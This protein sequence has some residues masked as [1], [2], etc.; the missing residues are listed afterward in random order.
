MS[1]LQEALTRVSTAATRIQR[2]CLDKYRYSSQSHAAGRAGN[3]GNGFK[4]NVYHCELCNGWHLT[5]RP[6]LKQRKVSKP[7]GGR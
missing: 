2:G 3:T 6:Q 5:K 4:L 1:T 7:S